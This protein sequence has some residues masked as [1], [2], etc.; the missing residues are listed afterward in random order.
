MAS[1]AGAPGGYPARAAQGP[2]GNVQAASIQA[3]SGDSGILAIFFSEFDNIVGPKIVY[4]APAG[5]ITPEDFD[6]VSEYTITKPDLCGKVV[7]VLHPTFRKRAGQGS[8]SKSASAV[9]TSLLSP[10]KSRPGEA[11]SV[12][13]KPESSL[14]AQESEDAN[15]ANTAMSVRFVSF[16]VGLSHERYMRNT[17]LYSVGFVLP[18]D[19]DASPYE[20]VLRKLGL[21]LFSMEIESGFLFRPER[22]AALADLLPAILHGLNARGECFVAVDECDTI[23]LKLFPP[24]PKPAAVKDSDVPVRVRDLDVLLGS[25]QD[26]GLDLCIRM[27]LPHIDGKSFVRAIAESSDVD[28]SLVRKALQHLLYY[29]CIVMIDTF[30]YSNIYSTQPRVQLLLRS[31]ELSEACLKYICHLEPITAGEDGSLVIPTS[32]RAASNAPPGGL[33]PLAP[34]PASFPSLNDFPQLLAALAD[35]PSAAAAALL[36]H[37]GTN[38]AATDDATSAGGAAAIPPL[39]PAFYSALA[40]AASAL[41]TS[42]SITGAPGTSPIAA[43]SP[44]TSNAAA[45]NAVNAAALSSIDVVFNLYSAF[46][47]G[48][49]TSDVCA[50]GRTA[51]LGIDDR[52]FISFGVMHGLI[53]RL[54]KYPVPISEDAVSPE[55]NAAAFAVTQPSSSALSLPG[56]VPFFPSSSSKRRTDSPSTMRSGSRPLSRSSGLVVGRAASDDASAAAGAA[57]RSNSPSSPSPA[58][59][60]PSSSSKRRESSAIRGASVSRKAFSSSS[61]SP[62]SERPGS[63]GP[64]S[65]ATADGNTGN[66]G[67][68]DTSLTSYTSNDN[69]NN[70]QYWHGG[71]GGGGRDEFAAEAA[72]RAAFAKT[73]KL[74]ALFYQALPLLDGSHNE[75]EICCQ[76]ACSQAALEEC[77]ARHGGFV[78]VLK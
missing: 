59:V 8:T 48:T 20:P 13:S 41:A 33:S 26:S 42:S 31:R 50:Q 70:S 65:G 38:T 23:A 47:A 67:G 52:R 36:S 63:A 61:S 35:D 7:S 45:A 1:P 27:I 64:I 19:A 29:G 76:L 62:S 72:E 71:G 2:P 32:P 11:I 6:A 55:K 16:P 69:H 9:T 77:L 4:Q 66:S 10:E 56:P 73:K 28:I 44:G 25:G 49:R 43:I 30:Q 53:R 34:G 22:K 54:H 46:G 14:K 60:P 21:Y 57:L 51:E 39:L 15:E 18:G 5:F 68:N 3:H 58:A 37:G 12:F 24:L 40:T 74:E 75:E 78:S 17:L